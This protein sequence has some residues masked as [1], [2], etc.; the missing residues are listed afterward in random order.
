MRVVFSWFCI[1]CFNNCITKLYMQGSYSETKTN[2]S[3]VN[4]EV[5]VFRTFFCFSL[6]IWVDMILQ[7]NTRHVSTYI[8]LNSPVNCL[9][10]FRSSSI[11]H[12][13]K[14]HNFKGY[15]AL[16]CALQCVLNIVTQERCFS[17]NYCQRIIMLSMNIRCD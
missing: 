7:V 1:L 4:R 3:A 8:Q 9:V 12:N 10:N 14:I 5:S 16:L 2:G 13:V 11:R 17:A 6:S 15:Q